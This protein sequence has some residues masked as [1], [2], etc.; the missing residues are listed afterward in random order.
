MAKRII[1]FVLTT[2]GVAALVMC[3]VNEIDGIG[4][5]FLT[6]TGVISIYIGYFLK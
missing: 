6:I 4:R 5:G 2:L 3:I 1:K